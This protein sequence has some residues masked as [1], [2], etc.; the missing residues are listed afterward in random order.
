MLQAIAGHD[1][2]D[3]A[4]ADHTIPAYRAGLDGSVKGMRIGI[5][6]HLYEDDVPTP[7]IV[8]QA[9]E[10]AYDVLR[11]L[12]AVLEDVRIRPAQQYHDVKITGAE[13]ELYAVHEPVLRTRLGDFGEDFLGRTLGALLIS[14]ADYMQASRQRRKMIADMQPL[15]GKYDAFVTAGPGPA[16]RLDAW[17]TISFWEKAF[18]FLLCDSIFCISDEDN[19]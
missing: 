2:K 14:S 9:L 5:I 12:G 13:S 8:K 18:E 10:A 1:P 7:G 6:R 19:A 3:P 16:G 11:G 17:R 4:S 15:Y